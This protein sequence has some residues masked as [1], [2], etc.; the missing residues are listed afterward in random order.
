[1]SNFY[2]DVIMKSPAFRSSKRYSGVDLLEPNM[3]RKVAAILSDAKAHGQDWMIYET[4]RSSERQAALF[5]QGATRLRTVG[6]HHY[7][8]ACDIVKEVNG[9][10]SWHGDFS[11]LGH[12]AVAHDCVWGGDWG[13]PL[14]HHS[15]VDLDHVQWC[16]IKDQ[17][18]LFSGS[19]YP[20]S[21]Y[22]PYR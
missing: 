16:A 15:F 8:L 13:A 6:V 4:Y 17:A 18:R 3:R 9:E 12:L 14:I 21:D 10:P 20:L 5:A 22:D 2:A 1:M 19:W 11:L 7:G